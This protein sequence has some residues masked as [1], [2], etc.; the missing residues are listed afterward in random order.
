MSTAYE[1]NYANGFDLY[2]NRYSLYAGEP[3]IAEKSLRYSSEDPAK[4]LAPH[5]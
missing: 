4:S 2:L 3:V 5:A 1:R